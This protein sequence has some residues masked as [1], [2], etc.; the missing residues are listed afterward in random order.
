[1]RIAAVLAVLML[2]MQDAGNYELQAAYDYM[3]TEE[4]RND[5][6][7][8]EHQ[9]DRDRF[10]NNYWKQLDPTPETEYNELHELFLTRLEQTNLHF[11]RFL[12][13]A[14][15]WKSD[16]GRTYIIYG[17]PREIY[18]SPAGPTLDP[19]YEVWVYA[20]GTPGENERT[21]ELIFEDVDDDGGFVL[22]TQVNFPRMIQENVLPEVTRQADIAADGSDE[23]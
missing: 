15:G 6:G 5:Y 14:D 9:W 3:F 2:S 21:A 10:W 19:K 20:I 8:L 17:A 11:S 1:M 23:L 7:S 12:E 4:E 22:L 18:R 16:M 13:F